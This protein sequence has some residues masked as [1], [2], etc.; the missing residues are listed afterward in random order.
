MSV[1]DKIASEEVTTND[2]GENSKP[3]N[4]VKIVNIKILQEAK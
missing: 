3:V 4:P 1:V 2:S